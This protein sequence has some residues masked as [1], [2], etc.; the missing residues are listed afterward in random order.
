MELKEYV[1]TVYNA[2][3]LG[4]IYEELEANSGSEFIPDRACECRIRRP[5][6]RNTHYYLTDE[7]AARLKQD[8]RVWDVDLTPEA[9]GIEVRRFEYAVTQSGDFDKSAYADSNSIQWGLYRNFQDAHDSTWAIDENP[10]VNRTINYNLTGKDVDI[11]IVDDTIDPMH[12][13]WSS[14]LDGTGDSRFKE[15]DWFGLYSSAVDILDNDSQTV[16]TYK[17]LYHVSD[18]D[19]H[20]HCVASCAAGSRHGMAKDAN[21]YNLEFNRP[22]MAT[23]AASTSGSVMTVTYVYPDSQPLVVGGRIE[24]PGIFGSRTISSFGTG[25]G[26]VGTYN[27]SSAVD[28]NR[29]RGIFTRKWTGSD[30]S[31]LMFDYLRVF[32]RK[33]PINPE[34]GK[35]NPTIA[36]CSFGSSYGFTTSSITQVVHRGT[37]YTP[38]NFTPWTAQNL[39]STFGVPYEYSTVSYVPAINTATKADIQDAVNDGILFVQAAGNNDQKI[40]KSTNVDY[41]NTVRYGGTNYYYNRGDTMQNMADTIIAGSCTS[42]SLNFKTSFSGWG[43]RVDVFA[44]GEN[45]SCASVLSKE[46]GYIN[47]VEVNNNVATFRIDL[48]T[49]EQSDLLFNLWG[50]E[51]WISI[52]QGATIPQGVYTIESIQ[53]EPLKIYAT[54][55]S[56]NITHPNVPQTSSSGILIGSY[57]DDGRYPLDT[58]DF[59]T[60]QTSISGTSFSAPNVTGLLACWM[61]VYRR[62]DYFTAWGLLLDKGAYG[63]MLDSGTSSYSTGEALGGAPNLIAGYENDPEFYPNADE[64]FTEGLVYPKTNYK[65]RFDVLFRSTDYTNVKYMG[66]PRISVLR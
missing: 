66:F 51:V 19:S 55:F 15:I 63:N 25:T 11:V 10:V 41:N 28:E 64:R 17:Y 45:V 13:E 49:Y 8:P 53:Y 58:R 14:T 1:V 62:M 42:K 61:Q 40:V 2:E 23:F 44:A 34:T 29:S 36:N 59:L 16:P 33:K 38:S 30:W 27:L 60:Y 18:D 20:G 3:D 5:L 46:I 56:I 35:R 47:R 4:S 24:G 26:R 21:I 37:T 9:L 43:D 22:K 39:N 50:K 12:P 65:S 6:S 54:L 32:H 48:P 57:Q 31:L 7:E 52:D